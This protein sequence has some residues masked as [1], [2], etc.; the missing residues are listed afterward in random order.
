M[1]Y[2]T[3]QDRIEEALATFATVNPERLATRMQYD[4]CAAY[5]QM[6][7]D[8]PLRARSLVAKYA[9]CP[10]DRWRNAFAAIG[11]QLDE[12][13]GKPSK[14]ADLDDRNERQQ[15]LAATEPNVEFTLDAK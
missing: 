5:L 14:P 6:S 10:V 1:Y 9:T 4:Y 11:G 2:L 13:E 7:G 8:E 12:I 15:L 3:L